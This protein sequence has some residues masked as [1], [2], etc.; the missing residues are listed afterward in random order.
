MWEVFC[1]LSEEARSYP[2]MKMLL[3]CRD[4]DLSHDDRLRLLGDV[5]SGY[6]KHVLG[7][8]GKGDI[9]AILDSAGHGQFKLHEKQLEILSVPFHLLLFLQGDP[10]KSFASVGE[11]YGRYWDRKR[12]NVHTYLGR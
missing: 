7:K 2:N 6:S 8:L 11:L 4:F 12:R 1:E 5:H 3:A 10:T 9:L